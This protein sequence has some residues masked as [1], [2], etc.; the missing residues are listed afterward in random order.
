[1][2]RHRKTCKINVEN[3]YDKKE[4]D[5]KNDIEIQKQLLIKDFKNLSLEVVKRKIEQI[6]D[7]KERE[8]IREYLAND[9]MLLNKTDK[10]SLNPEGRRIINNLQ[11]K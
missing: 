5:E 1:M 11:K 3:Y 7:P 10:H 2:L 4:R 8:S 6:S 9:L